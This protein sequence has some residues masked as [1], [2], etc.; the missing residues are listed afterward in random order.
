M[1]KHADQT[2]ELIKHLLENVYPC[3]ELK[4][5]NAINCNFLKEYDEE[6]Q[7]YL[8]ELMQNLRNDFSSLVTCEQKLVF[9][10]VMKVFNAKSSK[11]LVL[12]NLFDLMQLTRSK[13]HKIMAHVHHLT[14]ALDTNTFKN[15][16]IKQ[17]DLAESFS[18]TFIKEKFRWNKM[19]EDRLNSCSCFKSNIYRGLGI[20]T[21]SEQPEKHD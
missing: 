18:G 16:A 7:A 2:E 10:S 17:H 20:K 11:E 21:T 15:G 3:L 12:P 14:S 9:P 1:C 19:I 13:E 6:Q 5:Q 4:L 8:V